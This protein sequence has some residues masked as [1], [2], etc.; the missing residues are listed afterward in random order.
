MTPLQKRSSYAIIA[1]NCLV[2][3]GDTLSDPKTVLTWLLSALGAPAFAISMLVPIRESG[4]MLPQM[5]LSGFIQKFQK[6]KPIYVLGLI[7]QFLSIAAIGLSALFLSAQLAGYT[8]IIS[9]ALFA[10]ARAFCSITSKDLLG[11]AIPKGSRG[12]LSGIASS[13]SGIFAIIIAITLLSNRD[14]IEP[15]LL[16]YLILGASSMWLLASIAYRFLHEPSNTPETK[17]KAITASIKQ[18]LSL[19]SSDQKFR[20]FIIARTLLLGTALASPII[21]VI[22]QQSGTH[23]HILVS[24]MIAG[25][26]ATASSSIIW[27]KFS[28]KASHLAMALGGALSA[29]T[30]ILAITIFYFFPTIAKLSYTWPCLFFLFNIGYMGVRLG[31]TTWVVDAAEGNQRTNYVSTSNTII[32]ILIIFLGL[33]AAPLQSLQPI[34]PMMLYSACCLIGAFYALKLKLKA[35]TAG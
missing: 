3:I 35:D 17:A 18:R 10:T 22:A 16:A 12:K 29:L 9:L 1:S 30:G 14:S 34:Y 32:A 4:S 21:V 7:A 33:I 26:V 13:L 31:R 8:I 25:A 5:F 20:N 6:R 23:A 2:R 19:V 24:F 28:D 15:T 11:R 27:G